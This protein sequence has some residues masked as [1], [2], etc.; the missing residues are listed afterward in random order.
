MGCTGII[1]THDLM[2]QFY[3]I[4][5]ENDHDYLFKSQ[6]IDV[7]QANNGY[8]LDIK[9]A[10]GEIEKVLSQWVINAAGLESDLVAHMID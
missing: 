9:N 1:S 8:E 4:S 5:Q 7:K 3:K 10:Q 6:V 2:A